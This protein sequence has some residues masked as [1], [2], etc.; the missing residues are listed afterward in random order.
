MNISIP[1]LYRQDLI[2]IASFYEKT[3]LSSKMVSSHWQEYGKKTNISFDKHFKK[4]TLQAEGFDDFRERNLLNLLLN[5][6]ISLFLQRKLFKRLSNELINA[7]KELVKLQKRTISFN[8]IKNALCIDSIE[9]AN[10]DL[11]RKKIAIIGDGNGFMGLLIKKLYPSTKIIQINLAKV[12]L[13]DYLFTSIAVTEEKLNFACTKTDY[14][15][16]SDY[17][18]IPAETIFSMALEDVDFF[19]NIASMQEMNNDVVKNYLSLIRSQKKSNVGF[20]CCNR[21]RKILPDGVISV[22]DEYGWLKSDKVLFDE[23]CNWYSEF[24]ISRPP[25]VMKF[26]GI[27][28][29]KLIEI[30]P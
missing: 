3:Q 9:K 1:E 16:D 10:I 28:K 15:L 22:F 19:I 23:I 18:F 6:P 26:D 14:N 4:A 20:Y 7:V 5:I 13:F 11:K 30:E 24:P 25:F 27:H 2:K 12:L 17:N 8:C 21:E 29:H